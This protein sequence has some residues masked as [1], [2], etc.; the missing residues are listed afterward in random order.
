MTVLFP[1]L[2]P[3][4]H[5]VS[6]REASRLLRQVTVGIGA[7]LLAAVDDWNSITGR[8]DARLRTEMDALGRGYY[9]A[10]TTASCIGVWLTTR[11]MHPPGHVVSHP[12][13]WPEIASRGKTYMVIH[14]NEAEPTNPRKSAFC[15]QDSETF[16]IVGDPTHCELTWDYDLYT[17]SH[18]VR[19][20]VSAPGVD[21]DRFEV[22][23]ARVQAQLVSWR[24]RKMKWLPGTLL[25]EGAAATELPTR[26]EQQ[27]LQPGIEVKPP[28][29]AEGSGDAQE[30]Q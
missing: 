1:D 14:H 23:M 19:I 29:Q 8:H 22:P 27:R 3:A 16:G 4:F 25:P 18:I 20:W 9:I 11:G 2:N 10:S 7:I 6:C 30:A 26:D 17:D 15:A 5:P 28:Q 24:K 21:W 12:H 13:R